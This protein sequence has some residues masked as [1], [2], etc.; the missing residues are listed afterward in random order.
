[1]NSSPT[2]WVVG[3]LQGCK[4]ALDALLTHPDILSGSTPNFWFAGDLV[5]RGPDSLGTLRTVK[6]LGKQAVAVLGNHDLHLLAVVAGIR[7]RSKSDTFDDV[8]NAPDAEELIDW[9]RHRPLAHFEHGYL[10]VHA[11]VL[12]AWTIEKTLALADEIQTALRS[13]H[14]KD[15]LQDMYGNV[16][17]AWSNDLQGADRMRVIVNALTRMRLCNGAGDMDFSRKSD[18]SLR[19][20]LMPWFDVP[21]RAARDATIVFGHWSQL[22]LTLRPDIV[23][24]DSGCVWGRKL[25]AMR[26]HDRKLVQTSCKNWS[27]SR[28]D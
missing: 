20:T 9:L 17:V 11:G 13:P 23:C 28:S 8:I 2:T 19:K 16:P 27:K 4:P 12:P 1:M 25:T 21:E 5:N 6:A 24:L 10:M 22:G 15:Y 26:L 7:K 3:D 18:V 14:W